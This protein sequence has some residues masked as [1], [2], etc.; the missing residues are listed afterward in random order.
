MVIPCTPIQSSNETNLEAPSFASVDTAA[1]SQ[2]LGS[3]LEMEPKIEPSNG[4]T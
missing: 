3:Q 2:D 1:M 4:P